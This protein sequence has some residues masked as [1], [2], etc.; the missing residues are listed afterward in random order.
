MMCPTVIEAIA[1]IRSSRT[2]SGWGLKDLRRGD[3][4]HVDLRPS[5]QFTFFAIFLI[6]QKHSTGCDIYGSTLTAS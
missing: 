3:T 2:L 1:S 6:V 4:A 5:L